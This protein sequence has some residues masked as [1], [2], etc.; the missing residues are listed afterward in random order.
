M[1][2]K[3]VKKFKKSKII[4]SGFLSF[5]STCLL[6]SLPSLLTVLKSKP[7]LSAEKLYVS[8]GP[9]DLS[10]SVDSLETFAKSGKIDDELKFYARFI[11]KGTL[12]QTRQLLQQRV[13]ISP[14]A[15]SQFTYSPT[16]EMLLKRL[17]RVIETKSSQDGFYALRSALILAASDPEG[18]TV[19]N[20][21]RRYPTYGIRLNLALLQETRRELTA[22]VNY[23]DT[24]LAAITKQMEAEAAAEPP[25]NFS[26]L[27]DPQK[28]GAFRVSQRTLDLTN[29]RNRQSLLGEK[30]GRSFKV[31]LYLPEGQT[32]PAPV[33]VI[34]H[35]LGSSRKGFVYL[36]KHLASHGFAVAIPEHIGSDYQRQRA[37]LSGIIRSDINPVEFIDRPLDVKYLLDELERLSQ[38]DPAFAGRLNLQQVGVIGHSTGGYTALALAGARINHERLHQDCAGDQPTLNISLILQCLADRLPAFNYNLLDS[39]IKAAIAVDP[40]TSTILGPESLSDIQ[41]PTMIVGGSNDTIAPTVP[42]QIHPFIW[43]TTPEKYLALM[44]GSGHTFAD[45]TEGGPDPLGNLGTLFSGPDPQL[46]RKYLKA[47]SLAFVETYLSDRPE[48]RA[49]L[50]AAYAKA[51]SREPIKLELVRSLTPNQLQQAFGGP[52]PLP[53]IPKLANASVS[54]SRAVLEEIKKTGVLKAAIRKDAAP[55]GYVDAEGKSIG[56]CTSLLGSLA[57]QLQ[58]QL[59][60]P[61]KLE[62]TMQSTLENRFEI[63]RNGT[64]QM[65]CGPN[66]IKDDIKGIAFSTPF[67]ITGTHFLIQKD[68]SSKVNPLDNLRSL[69]VGVLSQTTTEQVIQSRYPKTRKVYFQGAT[70]RAMGVQALAQGN[71]DA[72]ANDG[73]LLIAEVIRQK[74]PLAN[75][76]LVPERP[77]TC[78]AYGMV[79]PAN[80]RQWQNTVNTFIGSQQSRKVWDTWFTNLYPYI[81]LNLDYCADR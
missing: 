45:Q 58:Q 6:L 50:S 7:A 22:F 70:G 49:F 78:D 53:I 48:Y 75:Y 32:Q 2:V 28:P 13:D 64:V 24:S 76:A 79:L 62:I 14:V 1:K 59:K 8:Y 61:V 30:I 25:V 41:I 80:D 20:V 42:E 21:M 38:S 67:F 63:V 39:R 56:Y 52:P 68:N 81:F 71:I 35:G 9:L 36:G 43:L 66:T 15:V 74:L 40:I 73:I 51:I 47:L 46:A 29:N 60:T 55:F 5:V 18:L 26:S 4:K 16:G 31:D 37:L 72:F 12:V 57:N 10:L 33:V 23:R 77:L 34:S 17:G 44:V 69:R 27:P 11:N 54:G 19:L 65:E 3:Q